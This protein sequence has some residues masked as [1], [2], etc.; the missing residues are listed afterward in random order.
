MAENNDPKKK[1]IALFVFIGVILAVFAL[2][3]VLG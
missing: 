3:E 1:K 2:G